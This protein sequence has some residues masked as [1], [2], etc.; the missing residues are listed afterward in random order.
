MDS[1]YVALR[2]EYGGTYM[3]HIFHIKYE[4]EYALLLTYISKVGTLR[5][6]TLY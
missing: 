5:C 6:I 2:S 3:N 1:Y 4:Y